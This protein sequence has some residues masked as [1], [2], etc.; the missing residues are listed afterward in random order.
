VAEARQRA[1]TLRGAGDAEAARIYAAAYSRDEAFYEFLRS[2][3]A[4]RKTLGEGTTVVLPP[5]HAF[6]RSFHTG[7]SDLA[8]PPRVSTPPPDERPAPA[9]P[10][11]AA[12]DGAGPPPR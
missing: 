5:G 11:P 9:P 8:P 7:G 2:L 1:E 6:F 3:E 4:Y 10:P 12:A